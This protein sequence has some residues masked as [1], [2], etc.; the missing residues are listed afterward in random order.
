MWT[1]TERTGSFGES[2]DPVQELDMG[3]FTLMKGSRV[4]NKLDTENFK[5]TAVANANPIGERRRPMDIVDLA[6]SLVG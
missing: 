6:G 3:A 2:G 5:P 1:T 4:N